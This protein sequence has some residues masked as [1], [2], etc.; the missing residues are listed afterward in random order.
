MDKEVNIPTL[1]SCL[2]LLFCAY[3]ISLLSKYIKKEKDIEYKKWNILKWIFIF[4]ALDEG[5]QI[6]EAFIISSIK[7]ILPALLTIVW[8]VPYG[9]LVIFGTSLFMPTIFKLPKKI[10]NLILTSGTVYLSG[11]IGLEIIGSFLV[12]TGDIRL[13]GISYG[14]ISTIEETMEMGGLIIFIHALLLYVF[15][16]QKQKLSLTFNL[17]SPNN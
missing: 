3:L 10:R 13:H 12:R 2:L 1:F 16:H 5:L 15:N 11:A 7:P 4:L 6:H 17:S 14:L 9:I 8:V